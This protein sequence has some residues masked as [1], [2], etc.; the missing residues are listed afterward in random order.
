LQFRECGPITGLASR[1]LVTGFHEAVTCGQRSRF[2][3]EVLSLQ[4]SVLAMGVPLLFLAAVVAE[5]RRTARALAV[6][7]ADARHRLAELDTV[8]RTAPVGLAFVDTD[9]RFVKVNDHLAEIDGLSARDHI[10]FEGVGHTEAPH[11]TS[12]QRNQSD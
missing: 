10:G 11:R 8:Y 6:S 4:L 12:P 3:E 9:L 7:E 2:V 1:F 5:R